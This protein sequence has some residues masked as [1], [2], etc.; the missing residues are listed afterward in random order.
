MV[1][2]SSRGA[3]VGAAGIG[4]WLMLRSPNRIRSFVILVAS[5]ALVW[6]ITPAESKLRFSAMGDDKTSVSR[7]TYWEHGIEIAN[8]HPVLGIGFKNWIPYYRQYYNPVGEL[9]HNFL[10]ECVSELGYVGLAVLICLLVVCFLEN[11]RTRKLTGP[12]A[13]SPDR[14]LWA[15]AHGLDG[16]MIGF[17]ISGSFVTVL[18]YPYLWMNIALILALSGVTMARS[19]VRKRSR[20]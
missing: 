9:P 11:A 1:A 12:T 17:M 2:S 10:I 16:A 5:S 14:M 18:Y 20:P 7:L 3:L 6:T 8:S 13:A 15:M 19:S 4:I